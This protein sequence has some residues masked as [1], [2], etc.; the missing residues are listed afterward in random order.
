MA[1][2]DTGIDLNDSFLKSR[3]SASDCWDFVDNTALIQDEVGHGTHTA[4]ILAKTAPRARIFCG[5]VWKKR[6]E[7]RNTRNTGELIGKVN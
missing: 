5:R 1:I 7:D 4:S 2:L 3:I 6:S